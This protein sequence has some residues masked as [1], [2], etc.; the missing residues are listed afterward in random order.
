[1]PTFFPKT[2]IPKPLLQQCFVLLMLVFSQSGF[3]Q[4]NLYILNRGG[5]NI[6][7]VPLDNPDSPLDEK[8]NQ[9]LLATYDFVSHTA[10]SKL[11]WCNG[12]TNQIL[13]GDD[14]GAGVNS[15]IATEV[16]VPVDLDI[17]VY[18]NKIY[19]ADNVRKQIF[20]ANLDGSSQEV[21][22]ADSFPNL[23]SIAIFPTLDLMVFADI[24]SSLIWSCSLTGKNKKV[25]VNDSLGT[26]IRLLI[27]T[28][29]QKLYWADDAQH[30][31]ERID[32]NGDKRE[33]FYQGTEA[34]LPFGLYLDYAAEQIYW[35]DY[36]TE[37]IMRANLDGS[38][39]APFIKSGLSDPV[40]IT[41]IASTP[42]GP[43]IQDRNDS[44][45]ENK[46]GLSDP[47][48]SAYPNPANTLL[49]FSSGGDAQIM[50]QIIILDKSGKQIYTANANASIA[51]VDISLLPE[52]MYSY[53]VI[54]AG[55]QL[56]GHFSIIH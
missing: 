14:K 55:R 48:V 52:G 53:R 45:N 50:E 46:S 12:M 34:E 30:Q 26:P 31:I 5:N 44:T 10:T 24:D 40:A 19:W 25:L 9:G 42:F 17:D 47:T 1:M 16:S 11:F 43:A 15:A 37:Q 8:I 51:Q 49:T 23:S 41:I 33:V 38:V 18:Q 21:V 27:D 32:F 6:L 28:I 4:K 36:G 39:A 20:R 2:R 7:S 3:A 54:I 56:S 13:S 29:H 22:L 35:T